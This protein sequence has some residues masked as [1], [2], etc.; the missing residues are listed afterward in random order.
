LPPANYTRATLIDQ[1]NRYAYAGVGT[2]LSMGTDAGDLPLQ[3]R[4][5]QTSGKSAAPGSCLPVVAWPLPTPD[6]RR[7][8]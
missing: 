7:P 8:R 4:A 2:V 6:P 5:D 3:V 1:L